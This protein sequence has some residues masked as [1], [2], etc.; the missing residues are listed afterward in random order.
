[1]SHISQSQLQSLAE[2]A[3]KAAAY[4]DAC[5]NG[6]QFVRLDPA[7][8]QSCGRLLS[9]VF[10]LVDPERV[11]PELIKQSPSARNALEALEMERLLGISRSGYYP[12]LAAILTRAS[13]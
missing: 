1:M 9:T 4:L 6:G 3:S 10:N 11:F 12:E 13:A 2:S 8:Y 7:Y 5:D